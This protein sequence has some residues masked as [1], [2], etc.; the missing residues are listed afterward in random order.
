MLQDQQS[1]LPQQP[2]NAD[3]VGAAGGQRQLEAHDVELWPRHTVR[4][5]LRRG[6]GEDIIRQTRLELN[7]K[8]GICVT[9]DYSGLWGDREALTKLVAA[10]ELELGWDWAKD[11]V[12]YLRSSDHLPLPQSVLLYWAQTIDRG[13]SCVFGNIF[14][15]L[16]Q[17]VQGWIVNNQSENK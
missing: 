1:S 10:F 8:R 17:A 15:R 14:D 2:A 11:A 12:I 9:S 16:P 5:F 13:C 3:A 4:A 6:D 7:L